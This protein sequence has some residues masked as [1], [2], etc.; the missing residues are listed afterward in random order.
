MQGEVR[1][2]CTDKRTHPSREIGIAHR[3]ADDDEMV[4]LPT[5]RAGLVSER[6]N[7]AGRVTKSRTSRTTEGR[8][9]SLGDQLWILDCASCPLHIEWRNDRAVAILDEI[10]SAIPGS[11]VTVDLSALPAR[12]K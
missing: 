10:L 11:R 1:F 9:R 7:R 4:I 5:D 8:A 12:F 6:R 2:I 3:Y